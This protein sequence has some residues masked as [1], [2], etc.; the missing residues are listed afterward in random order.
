MVVLLG[1]L[2]RLWAASGIFLNPD[3]A[4][5]FRLANQSSLALAYGQSA[6]AAHPPLL[7]LFL[8]YWRTL[9]TSDIWLRR[10]F[11][12]GP[13]TPEQLSKL[14]LRLHH[15]EGAEVYINGVQALAV[16]GYTL[17][18]HSARYLVGGYLDSFH[19]A[20]LR[21]RLWAWSNRLN[22]RHNRWAWASLVVV[23]LTDLYIRLNA[24][25][26]IVDPRWIS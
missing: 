20:S 1:F 14:L 25:G 18:C 3:E 16:T 4:L 24:M 21:Y 10:A 2:A 7:I 23:G 13:Q 15:D 11:N 5:H 19:R 12:P 22:A 26:V 9:S 17:S 6:T 8:Y